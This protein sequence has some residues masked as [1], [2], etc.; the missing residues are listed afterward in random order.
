[1]IPVEIF[2]YITIRLLKIS[3][4]KCVSSLLSTQYTFLFTGPDKE[5]LNSTVLCSQLLFL[6]FRHPR[7]FNTI[8]NFYR[9]GKLHVCDE[10]CSLAFKVGYYVIVF[11]NKNTPNYYD[12]TFIIYHMIKYHIIIIINGAFLILYHKKIHRIIV[13]RNRVLYFNIT[14]TKA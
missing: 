7:S 11:L 8:L 2:S 10:M 14:L 9:T 12:R 6:I 1:M 13:N 3:F 4:R 5:P